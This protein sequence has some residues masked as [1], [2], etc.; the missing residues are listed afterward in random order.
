VKIVH[1]TISLDI[2]LFSAS[3]ARFNSFWR[4]T[5]RV[6]AARDLGF[7][8]RIWEQQLPLDSAI[9]LHS[10]IAFFFAARSDFSGS[11]IIDLFMSWGVVISNVEFFGRKWK[12]RDFW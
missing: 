2:P 8:V 10:C 11:N 5:R 1:A 3:S 9:E 4:F 6:Y 7:C 12:W